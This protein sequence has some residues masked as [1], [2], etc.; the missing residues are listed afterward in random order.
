M[1]KIGLRNFRMGKLSEALNGTPTYTDGMKPAK[2]IS[3]NV[4]TEN[5][6]AELYADDALA[7]SD[8]TFNRANVTIGID[9]DDQLTMAYLLGHSVN[10]GEMVRNA[11]DTAPYVGFGRIITKMVNGVYKYDVEVLFKVKFSEPSQEDNTKG[12]N[13]EFGTTELSGV[14]STL[15]DGNWSKQKTFATRT[16]AEDYLNGL[17]PADEPTPATITY[18]VNGGTGTVPAVDTYVG[19]TILLNNGLA[20]TPPSGKVFDGWDTTLTATH[21]DLSGYYTVTDDVTLY[22]IWVAE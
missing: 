18:N 9:N 16:E 20:L 8:Y 6:D 19:A 21:G 3:C 14:A 5:N 2:A 1:A 13:V 10:N 7:E 4:E 12:E 22:A 11:Y 15:A 17:F